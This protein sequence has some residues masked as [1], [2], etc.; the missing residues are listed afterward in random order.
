MSRDFAPLAVSAPRI[1]GKQRLYFRWPLEALC[2]PKLNLT[3]KHFKPTHSTLYRKWF[4]FNKSI[5]WWMHKQKGINRR[6]CNNDSEYNEFSSMHELFR[7]LQLNSEMTLWH[8]SDEWFTIKLQ[9]NK[10]QYISQNLIC[11]CLLGRV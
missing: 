7:L 3:A 6:E 11:I 2:G 8:M 9:W 4:T 5:N 1:S 10:C